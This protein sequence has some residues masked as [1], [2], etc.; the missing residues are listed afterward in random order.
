VCGFVGILSRRSI[1]VEGLLSAR[2]VIAHRGPDDHGIYVSDDKRVGLAFRRLSI[3]DLSPAGHQP[4]ANEDGK[5]W[6]VFNGE[7]YNFASLRQNLEA[8]GHRFASDTDT[9]VIIHGYEEWGT[10][11]VN[12][13]RGMFAFAI[14]DSLRQRLFLARDRV[15][16]KPLFYYQDERQFIFG[17]ELKAVLAMR[18]VD[19][20]INFQGLYDFLTYHYV[21]C[22]QT[23]Y[24][25][26]YKLPPGHVLKTDETE[27][28]VSRYWDLDL[29]AHR[30]GLSEADAVE[31]VR[32]RLRDAVSSHLVSDVPVGL[33]LSGG[34]DSSTIATLMADLQLKPIH[35]FSI[36]F[37]VYSNNEL[38]YARAVAVHV[39]S[40][41]HERV[42][43]WPDVQAQLS[44]MLE[45]YDE[46][47]ADSSNI[48][49]MA[50]SQLA[51]EHVKVVLSGEGGDEAFVGYSWYKMWAILDR[52]CRN[53][54]AWA[55]TIIAAIGRAWPPSARGQRIANF[56]VNQSHF[57]LERYAALLEGIPPDEKR[58]IV[59][60]DRSR[61]IKDYDDYWYY[62]KYWREDV[63]PITRM[64]YL[65]IKTYLADQLLV[66]VDRASMAVSLEVRVPMLD[67]LLL[68]TLFSIPHEL[69]FKDGRTKYLLRQAMA[70]RLPQITLTRSKMG[71]G[72]P[73]DSWL[74][75]GNRKWVKDLLRGGAAVQMGLLRNDV[76][77][78]IAPTRGKWAFKVWMLVVLEMWARREMRYG[79]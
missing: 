33:F 41:H 48:P 78:R 10:D 77:D 35:T 23:A 29:V 70:D 11:V 7:V 71:F 3:I 43:T 55:R 20:S 73:L 46:P 30:E 22:P 28:K 60:E 62:R 18:K 61:E 64:Q 47:F 37:D 69:R 59:P 52:F 39:Q 58:Q 31:L 49:T 66:K 44:H 9:E 14:W 51:R 57:P 15:G 50:V 56:L 1:D 75:P 67:H 24:R 6:I 5:I 13:L 38:P 74:S 32:T 21:P 34:M 42:V 68:E 12:R 4:M 45:V 8:R 25:R 19:R 54:P 40:N 16:I 76:L 72:S 27:V 53:V 63:D 17:S 65:D 79:I 2:D 26:I 36:G